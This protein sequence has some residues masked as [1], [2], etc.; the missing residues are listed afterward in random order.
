[1][2]F[3]GPAEKGMYANGCLSLEFSGLNLSG[4]N[5]SGDGYHFGLRCM[6]YVNIHAVTPGLRLKFESKL[7]VDDFIFLKSHSYL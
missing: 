2:Q 7:E 1:M 4:M 3:L 5:C 6:P